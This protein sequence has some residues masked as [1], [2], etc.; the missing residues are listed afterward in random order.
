MVVSNSKGNPGK[1]TRLKV[2]QT[3]YG[4]M[5]GAKGRLAT[6]KVLIGG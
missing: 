5:K 3:C 6:P 2:R 4:N 1:V